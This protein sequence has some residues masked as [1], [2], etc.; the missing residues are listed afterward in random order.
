M[1][2]IVPSVL[3]LTRFPAQIGLAD[4]LARGVVAVR[5]IGPYAAI[6][7]LLPGGTLLAFLLWLYR[8]RQHGEPL[9]SVTAEWLSKVRAAWP[10][11]NSPGLTGCSP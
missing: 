3:S 1:S 2:L 6:E 11:T 5:A 4:W 9:R 8:R 10:S 7:I